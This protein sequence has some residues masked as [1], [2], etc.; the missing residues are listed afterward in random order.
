MEEILICLIAVVLLLVLIVYDKNKIK[1][2]VAK[3][4]IKYNDYS[5]PVQIFIT[6]VIGGI[7]GFFLSGIIPFISDVF[8]LNTKLWI[9]LLKLAPI[10]GILSALFALF[11]YY[12]Y[13]Y[14]LK[15]RRERKFLEE[16]DKVR[17]NMRN[18]S[19]Y[20]DVFK[21]F[22]SDL[23][24][25]FGTEQVNKIDEQNHSYVDLATALELTPISQVIRTSSD[26]RI[27]GQAISRI[28]RKRVLEICKSLL[29]DRVA[30]FYATEFHL[31]DVI[32][33]N[34]KRNNDEDY[35]KELK[36]R[37]KDCP[38]KKRIIGI[39]NSEYD[40][41]MKDPDKKNS[42]KNYLQWHIDNKWEKLLYVIDDSI[43]PLLLEKFGGNNT[44][45]NE[46]TDFLYVEYGSNKKIN[47]KVVFAQNDKGLCKYFM[48]PHK[49]QDYN[50]NPIEI[51][52]SSFEK[53]WTG[54]LSQKSKFKKINIDENYLSQF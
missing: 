8:E 23:A 26:I 38:E 36:K 53:L 42:L 32:S 9:L 6:L 3:F 41:I 44:S 52:K 19:I 27:Q 25:Q 15:Y 22:I 1:E 28:R 33:D 34:D 30:L 2:H 51:Y 29:N 50:P 20:D 43:F 39:K 14:C 24:K 47:K 37:I 13:E 54:N 48:W 46:L 45:C 5:K 12:S 49:N 7:L 18:D 17:G 16:M 21:D 35:R 4:I 31:Y 11:M 40:T 10:T